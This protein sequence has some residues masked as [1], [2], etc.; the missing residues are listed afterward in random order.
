MKIKDMALIGMGMLG[1][2]AIERYG[3]PTYKKM[4]KDVSKAVKNMSH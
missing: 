4:K 3:L 2:Y 1:M